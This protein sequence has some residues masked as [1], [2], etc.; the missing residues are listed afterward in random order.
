MLAIYFSFFVQ[1]YFSLYLVYNNFNKKQKG[2]YMK[3]A[4]IICEY[5]PFHNGHAYHIRRTREE[6]GARCVIALMSGNYV[7]RGTPAIMEKQLRAQMALDHGADI[8]IEL[9]LWYACGSAPYFAAGSVALLDSLHVVD[10]L[11]FGSECGD[12][13]LLS[14]LSDFLTEN[15]CRLEKLA[16]DY[17]RQGHSY[18]KARDLALRQL[19]PDSAWVRAAEEPNNLLALEYMKALRQ[20]HSRIR[21]FCVTRHASRHHESVLPEEGSFASASAIRGSIE[22]DGILSGAASAVPAKAFSILKRHFQKDFP[23]SCDDFSLLLKH[24]IFSEPDLTIYWDVSSDLQDLMRKSTEFS[25]SF[26]DIIA[27]CKNKNITWS[28]ISRSLLHMILG[29]TGENADLLSRLD[30]RLYYQ[31]LGFR[32]ESS[33]LIASMQKNAVIPM[34]RHCRP[35]KDPLSPERADL[36]SVERRANLLYHTVI[37]EKFH[38]NWKDRQIIV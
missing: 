29:M 27:R 33:H 13:G 22:S 3:T 11:S 38:Q 10:I 20:T 7:Q 26:T 31:I 16:S 37:G 8:V 35:L 32:K 19:A 2:I 17:V 9:P 28:R 30:H 25:S 21:P 24:I 14:E 15:H 5:N 6:T 23:V 34:V 1:F 12:I 4:A 18:P 36:L